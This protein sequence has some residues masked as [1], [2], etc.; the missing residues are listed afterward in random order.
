MPREYRDYRLDRLNL[1]RIRPGRQTTSIWRHHSVLTTALDGWIENDRH[2][3]Y[4]H[5]TRL[6]SRWRHLINGHPFDPIVHSAI[7]E[8]SSLGY[9]V[10]KPPGVGR[11]DDKGS[12]HLENESQLT[13]EMKLARFVGEGLHEDLLLTNFTQTQTDPFELQIELDAD[14]AESGENAN[15]RRGQLHRSWTLLDAHRSELRISYDASHDYSH[16]GCSGRAYLHRELVARLQCEVPT[17][18]HYS[19]RKIVFRVS[20]K[21]HESWRLS[22]DLVAVFDGHELM[23][24]HDSDNFATL[25]ASDRAQREY[26]A[27]TTQITASDLDLSRVVEN[28]LGRAKR[29]IASLRL[30]SQ[31]GASWVPSAGIPSYVALFG[32]DS[33]SLGWQS[34]LVGTQP[35]LGALRRLQILQGREMSDWRDE[36]PGRILHEAHSGP[37]SVLRYNPRERYYGSLTAS[38]FFVIS[39]SEYW[40]WTGDQ[41]GVRQLLDAARKALKW[42]DEFA[43]MK[44]SFYGYKTRSEQGVEHQSWKD[45][46]DSMVYE[47]GSQVPPPIA[48]C[49]EQGYVYAAKL[50]MAEM[51]LWFGELRAARSYLKE[52]LDL[53]HRFNHAFWMEDLG[54]F[55]M[56][57]DSHGRII[58]SI[59][60]NPLHA[61]ASGIVDSSRAQRTAERLLC[62]DLF[63]GWGF[64][65]LSSDHP[66]YDPYSYHRGSVW[67]TEAGAAALAFKLYGLEEHA[68]LVCRSQFEAIQLFE[69]LRF[70][71]VFS[72]HPR[73]ERHPMPAL[74]PDSCW[75]QA[76]SASAV[77]CLVQSMLGLY[78]Y[79]PMSMLFLDP[80]L[81]EWLPHLRL[82]DLRIGEA[83]VALDF[84]RQQD[85]STAYRV[86][87]KTGRLHL[88][89]QASPWSIRADP[90]DR[91]R[92]LFRARQK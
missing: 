38:S 40:H 75:P 45:S 28:S 69:Y 65:T 35:L 5:E 63:S 15:E 11:E 41:K 66:A 32:R 58:R 17:E 42:L 82:K 29:D 55:A 13:L 89:R 64:R 77:I 62:N 39:L 24:E 43:L 79:A 67:P 86:V 72:G 56:G 1:A 48:C 4:V 2:G 34:A 92:N 44:N 53:R 57:I 81:P 33:L 90:A 36:Q 8:H 71:E 14:F 37:R 16:Q 88:A 12:G 9:Y 19:N 61:M 20:L 68:N 50:R 76:W 52:A 84:D 30:D 23:P 10:T 83:T 78:P 74:Y 49:E 6:L 3:L 80:S 60:S 85:G 46:G 27:G 70:P 87:E 18:S 22:I 47:D 7:H 21:P 25:T 59:A 31:D 54:Y 73:D 91:L 51:L 26:L